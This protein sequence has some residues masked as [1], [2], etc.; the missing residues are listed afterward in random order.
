M[1]VS[2]SQSLSSALQGLWPSSLEHEDVHQTNKWFSNTFVFDI[3][4]TSFASEK[5]NIYL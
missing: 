3:D 2:Q 1:L 5:K 4:Q